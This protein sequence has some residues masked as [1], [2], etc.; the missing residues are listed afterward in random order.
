MDRLGHRTLTELRKALA[1]DP[2]NALLHEDVGDVFL[3]LEDEPTLAEASYRE[4]LR[5]APTSRRVQA[6]LLTA[7]RKRS[8]VLSFLYAPWRGL[9]RWFAEMADPE[10]E[11]IPIFAFI[12]AAIGLLAWAIFVYPIIKA[13]EFFT[14]AEVWHEASGLKHPPSK[15]R[16][17]PFTARM[18]LFAITIVAIW[19]AGFTIITSP[20]FWTWMWL[21]VRIGLVAVA[22]CFLISPFAERREASLAMARR[23]TI[24]GLEKRRPSR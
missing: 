8:R 17:L 22:A 4:A 21:V 24:E 7:I 12:S 13:Y 5:L 9:K 19:G 23:Q 20:G 1:L 6:K 14:A 10:S 16:P 3:E 18:A 15:R 2:E 11:S